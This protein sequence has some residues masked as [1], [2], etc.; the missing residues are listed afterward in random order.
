MSDQEDMEPFLQLLS[1]HERFLAGYVYSLIPNASDAEDILQDVKMA[2]WQNFEQFEIGTSFSAWSRQVAFYRVMAFR[3]KKAKE[4]QRF[5]FSE[6]C[7]ELL[8]KEYCY[9]NKEVSDEVSRLNLCLAKLP[10]NLQN[11]VTMRYKEEFGIE[12]IAL[13][14]EK[15]V[16]ACYKALSRVRLQLKKCLASSHD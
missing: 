10:A 7:Y 11:M 5:L 2:L 4:N 8:D 13:R 16:D 15:T 14:T 9:E 1:S 3:K 12:E 6:T